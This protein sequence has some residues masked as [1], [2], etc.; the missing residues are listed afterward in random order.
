MSSNGHASMEK[1]MESLIQRAQDDRDDRD[2]WQSRAIF[3]EAE[4]DALRDCMRDVLAFVRREA[5]YMAP[6]DQLLIGRA[7][8][9]LEQARR[10]V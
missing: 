10:R 7:H 5:G 1:V 4:R 8:A 9:L 3:A 2:R 6:M